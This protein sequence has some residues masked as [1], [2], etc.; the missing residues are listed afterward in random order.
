[1]ITAIL[2]RSE[3]SQQFSDAELKQ[4]FEATRRHF[5]GLDFALTLFALHLEACD[6]IAELELRLGALEERL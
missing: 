4:A 1:M 5:G 3:A 2:E 6:R